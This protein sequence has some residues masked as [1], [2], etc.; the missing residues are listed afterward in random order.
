[1]FS[2]FERM[3]AWRYLRARKAEGFV[4]VI[5][6]FSFLGIMLG[7]ATLIIVMSVMN[8]FR[9]ELFG[10][11]LGLNGHMNVYVP[12]ANVRYYD[13]LIPDL[14]NIEHV[15]SA[16]PVVEGQ[17]LM[18]E[19]GGAS[20][21]MVRGLREKDFLQKTILHDGIIGGLNNHFEGY[22]VAIGNKLAERFGLGLGDEISLTAPK[23]KSSP[24]G[25]IPRS[26]R[27]V[28]SQI[29]DVGMY[30]YNNAYIFMPLEAAQK[31]FG[32]PADSATFIEVMTD[33]LPGLDKI[34]KNV[35]GAMDGRAEVYDWRDANSSFVN[36]LNVERNVMFLILTMIIL[37]AAFNIISSM[38]MLVKDKSADIAIMRTMGASRR[39]MLKI[40]I[41]TGASIGVAGTVAGAGLG[42][43]FAVNIE[44]IREFLQTLTGTN[45]FSDEIYFLSTL[46]ADVQ[47]SEVITVIVMAFSLSVLA[48]LYPAWRAARLNPV[49]ALRYG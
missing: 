42:I 41:L 38:I 33:D 46:P 10:R 49:E 17:A 44:S 9:I 47:W 7:V 14:R 22:N 3:M 24:F 1:M 19:G 28:I 11:I 40:F 29:F 45:L 12:G 20:G 25:T 4:S 31:F 21:V 15:V 23:G 13:E 30:E 6:G 34:K 5:A 35:E 39:S 43:L 48:T 26:R 2:P 36:A 27:F 16:V 8:G 32:I 37:V 18:T